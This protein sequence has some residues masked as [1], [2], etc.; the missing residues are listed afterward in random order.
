[1]K[2]KLKNCKKIVGSEIIKIDPIFPNKII[3][4]CKEC[5]ENSNFACYHDDII[6][7]LGFEKQFTHEEWNECYKGF[8]IWCPLK[9]KI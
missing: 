3:N 9:N 6:A 8:P 2:K 4:F 7:E 1:M 5:L